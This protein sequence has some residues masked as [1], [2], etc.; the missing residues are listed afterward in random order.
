VVG[1]D[2]V[3]D[4]GTVSRVALVVTL[5]AGVILAAISIVSGYRAAY[6]WLTGRTVDI[7]DDKKL[8]N[9]YYQH[10]STNLITA[11]KGLRRAVS[12]AAAALALLLV[13]LGIVWLSPPKTPDPSTVTV[14]YRD[15]GNPALPATACGTLRTGASAK[16]I[17]V[18]VKES[19]QATV[20][21][22]RS[23]GLTR[24]NPTP[25]QARDRW[26]ADG[27]N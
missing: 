27:S 26:V 6:G 7:S 16:T 13:A 20:F 19:G 3:K 23:R 25:A 12:C 9:W 5:A 24:S 2:V 8:V 22:F 4:L 21:R 1:K 10:R 14:T 17:T 11:A 18:T 15:G